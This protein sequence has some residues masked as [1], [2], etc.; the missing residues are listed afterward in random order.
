[1]RSPSACKR[2]IQGWDLHTDTWVWE[3]GGNSVPVTEME[4]S[5]MGIEFLVQ[6]VLWLVVNQDLLNGCMDL[7]DK[8]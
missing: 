4:K 2:G 7:E 1:M 5:G 8:K 6:R 3:M